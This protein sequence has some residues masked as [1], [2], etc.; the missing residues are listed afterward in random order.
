MPHF[1]VY[2]ALV[3]QVDNDPEGE[4]R[5]QIALPPAL[6]EGDVRVFARV[7]VPYAGKDRGFFFLP[8]PGDE[9]LVAF[10]GGALWSPVILGALWSAERPAPITPDDENSDKALILKSG[11]RIRFDERPGRTALHLETPGGQRVVLEDAG[12]SLTLRQADGSSIAL[13]KEGIVVSAPSLTLRAER[14]VTIAAGRN[15]TIEADASLALKGGSSAKLE[16]NG[17]LV[18][19]GSLTQLDGGAVLIDGLPYPPPA[20]SW[21]FLRPK[22][23]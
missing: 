5:V 18:L 7:A 13:T 22:K 8:E 20:R 19:K 15:V 10:E 3:T 16:A 17:P 12:G 14:D 6:A 2:K 1:G 21:P 4:Y 23:A 11:V 9:V